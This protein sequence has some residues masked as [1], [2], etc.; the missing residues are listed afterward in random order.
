MG[1][2]GR[3]GGFFFCAHLTRLESATRCCC[4]QPAAALHLP[5]AWRCWTPPRLAAVVKE[6]GPH[7]VERHVKLC[8]MMMMGK[9]VVR[10]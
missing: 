6:E 7:A 8:M 4:L 3:R 10:D 1:W 9:V 2:C 5:A